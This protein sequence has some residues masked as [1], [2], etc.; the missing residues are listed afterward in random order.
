[1]P[2]MSD[3]QCTPLTERN[4]SVRHVREH[5]TSVDAA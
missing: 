3:N 1:L 2:I 5:V 4:M